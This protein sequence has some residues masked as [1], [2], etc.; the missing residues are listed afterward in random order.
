MPPRGIED[1]TQYT[2][3]D[4]G[5]LLEEERGDIIR[6]WSSTAAKPFDGPANLGDG[7]VV[8]ERGTRGKG[9][10]RGDKVLYLPIQ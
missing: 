2:A 7:D 10:G 6:T 3:N 5:R 9:G 8:V 4:G 1:A